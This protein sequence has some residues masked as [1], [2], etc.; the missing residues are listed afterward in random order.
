MLAAT[1]SIRME[2]YD[3]FEILLSIRKRAVRVRRGF[4]SVPVVE[5]ASKPVGNL[6]NRLYSGIRGIDPANLPGVI[7]AELER[8]VPSGLAGL[9]LFA[10]SKPIRY[11]CRN[12]LGVCEID[13]VNAV[14]S[15]FCEICEVP[16]VARQ[17]RDD[18]GRVLRE[19]GAWL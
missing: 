18:R 8:G 16:E 17:Y 12:G 2:H 11:L 5:R 14:F 9:S 15:V 4:G 10:F 6:Q 1:R 19:V 3:C 7:Q 13:I